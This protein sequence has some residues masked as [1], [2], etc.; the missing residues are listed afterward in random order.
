MGAADEK[1]RSSGDSPREQ[2]GPI[3]PTVNPEAE[4][5]QAPKAPG[6]HPVLYVV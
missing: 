4:S 6:I 3:L 2:T 1:V 5:V